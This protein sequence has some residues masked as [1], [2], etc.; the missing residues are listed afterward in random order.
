MLKLLMRKRFYSSKY[1]LYYAL[2]LFLMIYTSWLGLFFAFS[3]FLYSIIKLREETV[4]LPLMFITLSVVLFTVV[5]IVYQYSLINGLDAYL[6]QMK[7]RFFVRGSFSGN[8]ITGFVLI[9]LKQF[10]SISTNYLTAYL[11]IFVTICVFGFLTIKKAKMGLVFTK[12]GY[13]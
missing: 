1:L 10:K 7:H 8:S 3:V 13:R 11:P 4:F 5:L 6:A 9:K 12:N 2:F